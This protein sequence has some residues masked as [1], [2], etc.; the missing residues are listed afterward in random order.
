LKL[1][2]AFGTEQAA[3]P[4][5]AQLRRPRKPFVWTPGELEDEEYWLDADLPEEPL[6]EENPD[7]HYILSDDDDED[8]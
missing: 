3:Q 4:E 2:E 8:N 5:T 1:P 7:S 6:D